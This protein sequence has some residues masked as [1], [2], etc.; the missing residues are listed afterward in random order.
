MNLIGKI[1]SCRKVKNKLSKSKNIK[2]KMFLLRKGSGIC[3]IPFGLRHITKNIKIN[4]LACF[5]P[6]N[7]VFQF[8]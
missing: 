8:F 6:H 1:H 5:R 2:K 7:L 4:F 3:H